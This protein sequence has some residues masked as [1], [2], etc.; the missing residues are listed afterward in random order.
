MVP[1]LSAILFSLIKVYGNAS[2]I[3]SRES[4]DNILKMKLRLVA[5]QTGD[6]QLYVIPDD[7]CH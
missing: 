6:I 3:H 2:L 4:Q 1:L 7:T 5:S